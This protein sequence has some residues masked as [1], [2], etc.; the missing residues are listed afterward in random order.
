MFESN[1]SYRSLN[2]ESSIAWQRHLLGALL[3]VAILNV[4][5]ERNLC[6]ETE[7]VFSPKKTRSVTVTAHVFSGVPDPTWRL[8]RHQIAELAD[9][10]DGLQ[11]ISMDQP[12]EQP[13]KLGYRGFTIRVK[14]RG[15]SDKKL[16]VYDN[17]MDLGKRLGTRKDSGQ[18]LERWLLETAGNAITRHVRRTVQNE[19]KDLIKTDVTPAAGS[20][21]V[22][23]HI[24]SGV[25]DPSWNLTGEQSALLSKKIQTLQPDSTNERWEMPS[26]VGYRGFS[27]EVKP[28]L[29]PA[30]K[31]YLYDNVL[32][33][34]QPSGR[35]TDSDHALEFWML[36]TA[37]NALEPS[38]KALAEKGL[39]DLQ[40]K[41]AGR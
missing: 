21:R 14:Q 30:S 15:T 31:L 10:I 26:R 13:S 2:R 38:V 3:L 11:P 36:E 34:E 22:T 8:N 1:I 32:Q 20:V 28:E 5:S 39:E 18:S 27:F 4:A 29:G 24:F 37:G 12:W 16:F 9:R 40:T 25:P 7:S 23:L 6:A 19:L 17:V 41:D 35:R 33:M